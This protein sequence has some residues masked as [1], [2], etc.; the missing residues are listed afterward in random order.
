MARTW[1][2]E[3]TRSGITVKAVV[4]V[5]ATEIVAGVRTLILSRVRL[6]RRNRARNQAHADVQKALAAAQ[7]AIRGQLSDAER[8]KIAG[9]IS[10]DADIPGVLHA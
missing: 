8:V 10:D 9:C 6:M 1:T 5:A 2:L 3:L 7:R 4:P